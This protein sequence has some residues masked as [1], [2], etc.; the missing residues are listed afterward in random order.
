MKI[1]HLLSL[2]YTLT[3]ITSIHGM[4]SEK[5]RARKRRRT[6]AQIQHDKEQQNAV[7][8]RLKRM[9]TVRDAVNRARQQNVREAAQRR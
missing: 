6:K 3:L 5:P 2:F 4:P 8:N 9:K 7:H 1:F